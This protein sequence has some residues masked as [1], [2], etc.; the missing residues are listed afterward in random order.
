MSHQNILIIYAYER[1][2]E[3]FM[4]SLIRVAQ[5]RFEQIYY[6]TPPLLDNYKKTIS[7]TNV[8]IVLWTKAQRIKQYIAGV[9][10]P[11][12]LS[13]WKEILKGTVDLRIFKE[14]GQLYFAAAGFRMMSEN[15]IKQHLRSN[16]KVFLLGTWMGVDAYV[17]A[18]MKKKYPEI[19]GAYALAHSGE[20]MPSRNP[21]L[22][23][24]FHEFKHQHLDTTYF[25]SSKVLE[26]YYEGMAERNIRERFGD[27]IKVQHLGSINTSNER[28]PENQGETFHILSCSRIDANKRI[29]RIASALK[30]WNNGKIKWTHIGTG[31]LE[32]E[33]KNIAK[34]ISYY[35]P[36]VKIEFL[37]QLDNKGV[38]TYYARTAVDVFI[39]VSKSEGLPISIMEAMSFGIPCIATNVGGTS[40][41]VNNK[42]GI[43]LTAKFSDSDLLN[44]IEYFKLMN[45]E[46]KANY[47]NCSFLTWKNE[48]DAENN[49]NILFNDWLNNHQYQL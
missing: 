36:L 16:D 6:I 9:F 12:R 4:Q 25:I 34:T 11:L 7:Y 23:Q 1:I 43:L 24:R 38:M 21:H 37:G 39:N 44:A 41:I 8:Q 48:Y 40:E 17:A 31:S 47:Q 45:S 14:M 20:V 3:P 13:F 5:S 46:N 19:A 49:A 10:S 32:N 42:S 22:K 30:G 28:N 18:R 15:I 33:V 2:V 27:R 35:N 29:E 26:E